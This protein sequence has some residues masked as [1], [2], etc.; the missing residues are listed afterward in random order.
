MIIGKNIIVVRQQKRMI[1]MLYDLDF[2][3]MEAENG[4][5]CIRKTIRY[6]P[7][8]VIAEVNTP[9]LNGLSMARILDTLLIRIPVILTAADAKYEKH[10]L[11]FPNVK[12]Y[13]IIP[14]TEDGFNYDETRS[15]FESTLFSMDD[16]ELSSTEYTYTFRQHEWA[17]LLGKSDKKRLMIVEDDES[18]RKALLKKMDLYDAYDLFSAKDGLEGF[19]K[20]LLVEPDL[21]LTDIKMPKLDGF[22]MSQLFY[23]LNKPLP[24]VF[25]TAL[26]SEEIKK[27]IKKANGVLGFML[28][29]N[30]KN[31]KEFIEQVESYLAKAKMLRKSWQAIYQEG[32]TET[33]KRGEENEG[34]V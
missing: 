22:A 3:I 2:K 1:N 10:A 17:N 30:L 24:L 27:K 25:L 21:I 8:L 26:E 28:K 12:G 31:R 19:F 23:I 29:E 14:G 33:L 34:I 9:N 11:S 16:F 15:N 20:S 6:R 7:D 4:V 13:L 18:Y 32:S 5:D